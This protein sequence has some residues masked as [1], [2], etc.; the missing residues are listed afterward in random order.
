MSELFT[1]NLFTQNNGGGGGTGGAVDSVNGKTGTVVLTGN[2][3]SVSSTNTTKVATAVTENGNAIVGL[4]ADVNNLSQVVEGKQD[5][6]TAG[7]GINIDGNTISSTSQIPD[8]VYTEDNLIAGNNV[9]I[10][11]VLP[12]G[13]IDENT[14]ACWHFDENYDA[15]DLNGV[16][17]NI[18][19][20]NADKSTLDNSTYKFAPKALKRTDNGFFTAI[21][22]N[23]FDLFTHDFTIDFWHR[24]SSELGASALGA[25]I[26][27][28]GNETAKLFS[29]DCGSSGDGGGGNY[30]TPYLLINS[31]KINSTVSE[32][33]NAWNHIACCFTYNTK[34]VTVYLNGVF[35]GEKVLDT[36]P[37]SCDRLYL[38][39]GRFSA[40]YDWFDELR[41]SDIARPLNSDGTFP[42][43]TK[44][45]SPAVPTGKK[46]IN[47]IIPEI[48]L[49]NYVKKS[50]A[51]EKYA[52]KA[53]TYTKEETDNKISQA[54]D[55]IDTSKLVT[56]DTE[57]TITGAK[58]FSGKVEVFENQFHVK[59]TGSSASADLTFG[60]TSV[61]LGHVLTISGG[62]G[63]AALDFYS[64]YDNTSK[65][66]FDNEKGKANGVASLD[67]NAKIPA[68]QIPVDGTT[69]TVNET[70]TI[71][72]VNTVHSTAITT[73]VK[74]TQ[75]EYDALTT[76]DENTLY[77]IVE[78]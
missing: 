34:T 47:A 73:I 32:P 52:P 27:R 61:P 4:S 58:K 2:D 53:N 55:G 42:V 51:E 75:A 74:L 49:S 14:L 69:I 20:K 78:G 16:V 1:Q 41:I 6:L 22:S 7:E 59:G 76:K 28:L 15:V 72:T 5:K 77:Y 24:I 9:T 21:D 70:G 56:T 43:P 23:I 35:Y 37:T 68:A 54:V 71:S 67:A 25:S 19:Y 26:L 18:T 65:A 13:G 10:T 63:I 38:V 11:K 64:A 50:D 48:D 57:Q 44:P 39:G 66:I 40:R 12:E 31:S 30:V 45:Y 8:N 60:V 46:Q 17:S 33:V 3:L 29:L 62:R 36:L